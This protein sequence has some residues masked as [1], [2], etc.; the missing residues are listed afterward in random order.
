MQPTGPARTRLLRCAPSAAP[1]HSA[2]AGFCAYRLLA[3]HPYAL[4][5]GSYP[6]STPCTRYR[7]GEWGS[8]ASNDAADADVRFVHQLRA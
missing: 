5:N 6:D 3:E 8:V 1:Y 2:H 7:P 4:T